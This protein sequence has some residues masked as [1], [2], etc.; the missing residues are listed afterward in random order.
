MKGETIGP[1]QEEMAEEDEEATSDK[2]SEETV[3][4]LENRIIAIEHQ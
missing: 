4:E 1:P 2:T 3:E